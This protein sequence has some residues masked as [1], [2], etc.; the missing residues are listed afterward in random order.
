M[1]EI[2]RRHTTAAARKAQAR[3]QANRQPPAG[4]HWCAKCSRRF[5]KDGERFCRPCQ[6]ESR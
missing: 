5:A 2:T 6:K 1:P 4:S 3:G